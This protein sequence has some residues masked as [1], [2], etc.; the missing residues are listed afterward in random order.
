MH[1]FE[2]LSIEHRRRQSY[3]N[4]INKTLRQSDI[5]IPTTSQLWSQIGMPQLTYHHKHSSSL[6]G[7]IPTRDTIH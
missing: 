2:H 4:I 1:A 3:L 5:I 6:D 7:E